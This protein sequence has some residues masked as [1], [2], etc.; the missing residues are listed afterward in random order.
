MLSSIPSTA[1]AAR[2]WQR[3]D[4]ET[5][6]FPRS[7]LFGTATSAY[8][9]EGAAQAGGRGPSIWDAFVRE[10]GAVKD[11]SSGD[12][13][14]DQ[15]NR[16]HEDVKLMTQMGV[17]AYRFSLSWSRLMPQGDEL[18]PTGVAYCKLAALPG[19]SRLA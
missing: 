16:F 19:R 6:R 11:G 1:V 15:Y 18:N 3:H 2:G 13:A 7:F 8:Q 17:G 12:V 10:R 14:V 5:L 9:V 4:N